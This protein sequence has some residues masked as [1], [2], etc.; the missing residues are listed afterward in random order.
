[1]V[2]RISLDDPHAVAEADRG[3]MLAAV[4]GLGRQLRRGY[5]IGRDG[6]A[7]P[8]EE[9]IALV[10]CGMGGSGIAGDVVRSL[11]G[12]SF[13]IPVLV[14]KGRELPSFC[15]RR[16]LVVAVSYSGDTEEARSCLD[17]GARR[18][19]PVVAISAGGALARSAGRS[20]LEHVDVPGDAGMPRA[21]LGYLAGAILGWLDRD[22]K[23]GLEDELAR[24]AEA[25]DRLGSTWGPAGTIEPNEPKS[26][27]AFLMERTPVV[28]GSEGLMEA[29]A[30]RF[31]NQLNENAKVPAFSS[32]LPELTHNEVEGWTGGRADRFALVALRHDGE[33]ARLAERFDRAARAVAAAGLE[34]REVRVDG[35]GPVERL[36]GTILLGDFAS[37][38]LGI[39]R[40]VDPTPIPTITAL[41]ERLAQ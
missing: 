31:R 9:P 24:A 30:L 32:I 2:D 5:D 40:G 28:W 4:A 22:R 16:T 6:T 25:L 15:G 13:P 33:G 26:L 14:H 11:V 34:V 41:K 36:F 38:Y 3:A 35:A 39:L 19:C 20:G 7:P 18:G 27:A 37:V 21:A 12:P 29:A 8:G 10:V 17:E 1:M 23:L